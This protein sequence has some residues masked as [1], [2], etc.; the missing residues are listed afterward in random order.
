[1]CK[2]QYELTTELFK[3]NKNFKTFDSQLK[4]YPEF[5]NNPEIAGRRIKLHRKTNGKLIRIN[6]IIIKLGSLFRR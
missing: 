1:M 3:D 5:Y 4:Q 2:R 6:K